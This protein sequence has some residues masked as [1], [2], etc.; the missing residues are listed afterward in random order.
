MNFTDF[1]MATRGAIIYWIPACTII[2]ES[3]K[4]ARGLCPG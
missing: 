1:V 3:M 4:L 2:T